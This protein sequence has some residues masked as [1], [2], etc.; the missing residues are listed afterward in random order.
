MCSA[1]RLCNWAKRK[2]VNSIRPWI[3]DST[4]F[5]P[6]EPSGGRAVGWFSISGHPWRHSSELGPNSCIS[7]GAWKFISAA[8]SKEAPFGRLYHDAPGIDRAKVQNEVASM[9]LVFFDES[10]AA[11]RD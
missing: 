9:A 10:L 7:R 11:K 4:T 6:C 5:S 1:W 8:P 2:K 3:I